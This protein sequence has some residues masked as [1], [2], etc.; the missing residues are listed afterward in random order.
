[1]LLSRNRYNRDGFNLDLTYVTP[2]CIAM[3][4]P[5]VRGC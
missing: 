5:E 4:R 2:G 3:Q 1:M